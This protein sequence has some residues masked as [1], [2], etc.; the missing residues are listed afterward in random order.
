MPRGLASASRRS[1]RRPCAIMPLKQR[2]RSNGSSTCAP[3]CVSSMRWRAAAQ[4]G[5]RLLGLEAQHEDGQ[6]RRVRQ[7][8][9]HAHAAR[10]KRPEAARPRAGRLQPLH[11]HIR[12]SQLKRSA[13]RGD[14][15]DGKQLAVRA[16]CPVSRRW[17]AG[18]TSR[19]AALHAL[20]CGAPQVHHRCAPR[21]TRLPHPLVTARSQRCRPRTCLT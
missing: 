20:R 15:A 7:R 10:R 14:P 17:R 5:A 18:R 11:S 19:D 3:R 1:V 6:S 9:A 4:A 8:N 16:R 12:V 21:P 2:R 13:A